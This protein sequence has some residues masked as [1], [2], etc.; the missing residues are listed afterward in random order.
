MTFNE[1]LQRN[2]QASVKRGKITNN[3]SSEEFVEKIKEEVNELHE[4]HVAFNDSF[5]FDSQELADVILVCLAMAYHFDI[6]I[7][8]EIELKVKFNELRTD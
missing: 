7:W 8:D 2:Y 4:S 6:N 3:T 1:A 5:M